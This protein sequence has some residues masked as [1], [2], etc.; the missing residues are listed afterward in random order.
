M[1]LD[2]EQLLSEQE[3]ENE[4]VADISADDFFTKLTK[5]IAK[6][7]ALG[8]TEAEKEKNS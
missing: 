2:F 4:K 6:G 7:V 5:A 3:V 8:I 1:N